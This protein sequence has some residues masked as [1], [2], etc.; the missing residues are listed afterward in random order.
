MTKCLIVGGGFAGLSAACFL[1]DKGIKVHLLEASPKLGGRAYSFS[2]KNQIDSDGF[3][4]ENVDNGQH[5]LMGCYKNTLEFLRLIGAENNVLFQENLKIKFIKNSGTEHNL[6]ASKLFYPVNLLLGILNYTAVSFKERLSIIKLFVKLIFIN[7]D[8]YN[9]IT[10][11][12]WLNIEKQSDGIIKS[13][14]DI[15][16]VGTLN[17]TAQKASAGMFIKIL[18]EIFFTGNKSSVVVLP[19][20]SLS[21]MYCE[22][23]KSFI[24]RNGGKVTTSEKVNELV[25]ENGKVIKVRTA[26][27]SYSDFDFVILA[28]PYHSFEKIINISDLEFKQKL[29]IEYS[30]ILTA[31]LWLDGNPFKEKFYGLIDSKVHWLFNH[32]KYVTIVTSAA[33]EIIN[34]KDD[35]L[36]K[37]ICSE[38]EKYFPIFYQNVVKEYLI[39]KEKRATFVPTVE[40]IKLRNKLKFSYKNIFVAGDW[41]NTGLPSTI[42][43]AV[44]SGRIAADSVISNIR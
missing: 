25:I 20:V 13:L 26:K 12:Q 27:D 31:H 19:K 44:L 36:I 18:K 9:N 23:S 15:I 10:V 38:L 1:A 41:S 6:N 32:G 43:G 2:Y 4:S 35:E 29:E 24:E 40:L 17:T 34:L 16:I 8:D 14:W 11:D 3:K 39:L 33:D 28:V 30:P 22:N 21:E 37:I 7:P 42:E 5:I